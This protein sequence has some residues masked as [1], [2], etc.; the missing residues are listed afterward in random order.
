MRFAA[1][2]LAVL[3]AFSGAADLPVN[4]KTGP[5]RTAAGTTPQATASGKAKTAVTTTTQPAAVTPASAA[6]TVSELPAAEEMAHVALLQGLLEANGSAP[7]ANYINVPFNMNSMAG[8]IEVRS[9]FLYSGA[10]AGEAAPV[11]E[12]QAAIPLQDAM[13]GRTLRTG[14]SV[15]ALQEQAGGTYRALTTAVLN[16]TVL[17]NLPD[18]TAPSV[19]L[20]LPVRIDWTPG[21]GYDYLA[22]GNSITLHP[23][24]Q[25]WPDAM[26]MGATSQ[27]KD[28][29]H[30]VEQGLTTRLHKTAVNAIADNLAIWEVT[31]ARRAELKSLLD[32]YLTPELD[33]VTVELGENVP[34]GDPAFAQDFT[35]LVTHIRTLA[36]NAQIILVSEFWEDS[37]KDAV[38]WNVAAALGCSYV[39][40]SAIRG[41]SAYLFGQDTCY[42]AKGRSFVSTHPGT[43]IH[44]NNAAMR[45]IAEDILQAV[46]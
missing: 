14:E 35:D 8:G 15:Q 28:Y 26:G 30:L 29:F 7:V 19:L 46:K 38:K 32:P 22:I 25:F 31:P 18:G 40:L 9:A 23:V 27:N 12:V 42:D 6:V 1:P 20:F 2:V 41:R 43:A 13:N 24:N 4:A 17:V 5:A 3:L 39:D 45:V 37:Y 44:P 16:G 33:L 34:T 11:K 21:A 36:P 10:A